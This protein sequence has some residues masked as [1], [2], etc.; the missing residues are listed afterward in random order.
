M[1][2]FRKPQAAI[3]HPL[4]SRKTATAWFRELHA[5]DPIAR[6]QAVARAIEERFQSGKPLDHGCVEAVEF[7]DTELA[8]D[9]GRLVSQY[10]ESVAKSPTVAER[11][12]QAAHVAGNGFVVAYRALVDAAAA[13]PGDA[14]WRRARP[15]LIGRLMHFHGIDSKLRVLKSER[16]IPAKWIEL[17]ATYREAEAQGLTRVPLGTVAAGSES[18]ASTIEREYLLVLFTHLLNTGTLAPG[19]I[20]WACVELRRWTGVLDLVAAPRVANGFAVDLNARTGLV[21][22]E[23]GYAD[24]PAAALRYLDTGPLVLQLDRM[25]ETLRRQAR[26]VDAASSVNTQHLAILER[27]RL[28]FSPEPPPAVTRD[29]R[30]AVGASAQVRAGLARICA[31][32]APDEAHNAA[33]DPVADEEPEPPA[34]PVAVPLPVFGRAP[35]RRSPPPPPVE[36]LWRVEDRSANGMR[37]VAASGQGEGVVL[38]SLLA[39]RPPGERDWSLGIVRRMAKATP[40]KV[41]AGVALI[42]TRFAAVA[43]HGRQQAREDMGFVVDGVDVSTIGNRFDGLY[44]PPPSRPDRPVTAK[45]M[46]VPRNEYAPGRNLVVITG[47][48]VYTIALR[49]VLEQQAGWTWATIEIVGKSSRE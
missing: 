26:D 23:R 31:E 18:A 37:I 38:G 44:L 27:L 35:G 9:R 5:G 13:R 2:G 34:P 19:D 21:R 47:R 7:L 17:H 28:L 48:S 3:A 39:I 42:A 45:T 43:L 49:D 22:R 29:P 24:A 33:I 4:Q 41:D 32:L 46:V 12:W 8:A 14:R 25:R 36:P 15:R 1:F 10:V 16:W 6:L 40:D 20:D 30:T 11:V